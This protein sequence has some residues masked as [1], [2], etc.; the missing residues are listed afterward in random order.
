[1][2]EITSDESEVTELYRRSTRHTGLDPDTV[3]A[4][5]VKA[6]TCSL[7][8]DGFDGNDSVI[9]VATARRSIAT[10]IRALV[11]SGEKQ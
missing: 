9:S 6:E 1:M 10:A 4:C 7:V 8:I 5:A 3:E 11:Q 2:K